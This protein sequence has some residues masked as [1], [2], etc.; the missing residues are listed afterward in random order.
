[1]KAMTRRGPGVVAAYA[2]PSAE[3]RRTVR[4][5][6][7]DLVR[8]SD[9]SRTAMP[10][11][12]SAHIAASTANTH[13]GAGDDQQRRREQRAQQAP[14]RLRGRLCDV[15]LHQLHRRPGMA[16]QQARDRRRCRLQGHGVRSGEREH[17]PEVRGRCERDRNARRR[18]GEDGEADGEHQVAGEPIAGSGDHGGQQGG[19]D[20]LD[21]H[22]E[23]RRAGAPTVE[24]DHEHGDPRT[25]LGDREH[26]PDGLQ[27]AHHGRRRLGGVA[28]CRHGDRCTLLRQGAGRW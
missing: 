12:V 20:E 26:E 21:D 4:N 16:D 22:R 23:A 14:S 11:A 6:L 25:D 27:T 8:S 10:T 7:V 1:M 18:G 17:D 3:A 28:R 19:R 15:P 9:G 2:T 13:D 24:G 5:P